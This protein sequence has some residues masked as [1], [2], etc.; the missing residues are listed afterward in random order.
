MITLTRRAAL[1]TTALLTLAPATQV[2]SQGAPTGAGETRE[3][4]DVSA[5]YTALG[6]GA[7]HGADGGGGALAP[8][9]ATGELTPSEFIAYTR[10]PT[11]T[12]P[13]Y[14]ARTVSDQVLVTMHADLAP[15]MAIRAP[16]G[17]VDLGAT[18]YRQTGC[19][20]CHSNEAQGGAQGPR[21]G[22][23]P[24]SFARFIWYVRNPSGGMPPY[25]EMVMS[26]QDLADIYAFLQ[27]RTQPPA[28]DSIPLLA[29]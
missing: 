20:Q 15:L 8:S 7:C 18:L 3:T 5:E 9:I 27:A 25:T 17:R 19:Y 13:P 12:M 28:V 14:G 29:P 4:A 24:V 2:F 6:C 16:A 11:G 1:I 22:P 26:A 21:I 10:R 23:D